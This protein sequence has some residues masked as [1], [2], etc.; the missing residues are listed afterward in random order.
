MEAD[1]EIT[2]I[3]GGIHG[4]GIAQAAAAA[5]YHTLV[6]EQ[7]SVAYAT[8]SRSS[9]LIHGGL[10]YLETGQ[11]SLVRESLR[12]RQIL[13]KIAP[14]LVRLVPFH[15]PIYTHNKRHPWQIRLGLSLYALLGQLK[16][17]VRFKTVSPTHWHT[18]DGLVTTGLLRVFRYCDGQTDDRLLTRAVMN[19]ACSLGTRLECPAHFIAAEKIDRGYQIE[20]RTG[21]RTITIRSTILVNAAGPWVN[22][23]ADTIA[24]DPPQQAIDL[25]QGSHIL[26]DHEITQGVY[27]VEAPQD[28]RAVFIMPYGKQTLVGTTESVYTGNP[29]EVR[30]LPEEVAYLQTA[31]HHYFPQ[32][33]LAVIDSYAGLRVLP[34]ARGAVFHRPRSMLF[35]VDDPRRPN[36]I[37]IYGGKLTAYR[38]TATRILQVIKTSL[39]TYQPVADT[40]Q[41]QLPAVDSDNTSRDN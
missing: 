41:L 17:E 11:F 28:Q 21:D 3:G 7:E 8:S 33:P 30:P 1:Y 25:V 29:T 40:R 18:L 32:H 6:L 24:P 36:Y 39:P 4:A 31:L 13:Q 10:R 27:Y 14:Q 5:G 16:Q 2:I 23:V 37:A 19:S 26:I 15:I 34:K 22:W 12:E 35:K 38:A 20:Y 9:K